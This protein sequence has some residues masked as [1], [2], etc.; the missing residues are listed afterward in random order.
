LPRIGWVHSLDLTVGMWADPATSLDGQRLSELPEAT[1]LPGHAYRL[2]RGSAT[3][4]G[5]LEADEWTRARTRLEARP[6]GRHGFR[7][8]ARGRLPRRLELTLRLELGEPT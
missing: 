8:R 3:L 6:D 5:R 1:E 7:L 2:A 4:S